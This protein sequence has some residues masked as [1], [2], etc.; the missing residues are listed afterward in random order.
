MTTSFQ[1]DRAIREATLARKT[2]WKAEPASQR[3]RYIASNKLHVYLGDPDHPLS[4]TETLEKIRELGESTVLTARIVFG[5]WNIRRCDEQLAKDGSAAIRVEDILEWRGVQKH[6]R[7]IYPGSQKRR[8]DGY[9]WKHKQQVHRD[10]KLLE[11]CHLRGYHTVIVRGRARQF[12]VDGPYLR[13][14]SVKEATGEDG[15]EIIGYFLAPGAW[16]NTYEEHGNLFLAEIDRRIFQLH[17]QNEQT[18]LRIALYLTEHWRQHMRSGRYTEPI[19]MQELL[20]ASMIP[21]DRSNLTTRFAPRVEAALRR[22]CSRSI[23][24][25]ACPLTPVDTTKAQWG[26]DWLMTQWKILPPTDMLPRMSARI[27]EGSIQ[28]LDGAVPPLLQ[29]PQRRRLQGKQEKS[30]NQGLLSG[31]GN[32]EG[33]S[34]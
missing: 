22:L 2:D 34:S 33:T 17:P 9:Q 14:T 27:I 6:S 11:L 10:I 31:D 15:E 21:I 30:G 20:A 8:T 13:V 7:A 4:V 25:E 5:L 29:S 1:E 24:G 19:T 32:D 3:Y 23:V 26:K 18:A 28:E 16:I 12:V